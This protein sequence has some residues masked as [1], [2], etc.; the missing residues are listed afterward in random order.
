MAEIFSFTP[1]PSH[2]LRGGPLP[3]PVGARD[4]TCVV[5][6]IRFPRPNG[7]RDRVRGA[8]SATPRK[9]LLFIHNLKPHRKTGK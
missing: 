6:S 5:Q 2:R 3:L 4:I 8:A 9:P 7:E 1:S